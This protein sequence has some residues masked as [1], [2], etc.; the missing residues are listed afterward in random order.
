MRSPDPGDGD[1]FTRRNSAAACFIVCI[2]VLLRLS[3]RCPAGSFEPSLDVGQV[4]LEHRLLAA[5]QKW[6]RQLE[7]AV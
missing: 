2:S 5:A 4:A 1:A 7:Q 3:S 6:R